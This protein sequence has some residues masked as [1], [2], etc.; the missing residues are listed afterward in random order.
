MN[1]LPEFD[2]FNT[3]IWN[4][5]KVTKKA[6]NLSPI[7]KPD[8]SPFLVHMTGKNQILQILSSSEN[9]DHGLI[10]AEIP[11]QSRSPWY[12][13]KIVCFTESVLHSIDSFRYIAFNRFKS[14]LFYG[15][16]F[17]KKKLAL[18]ENVRPALYID[19]RTIGSLKSLQDSLPESVE[20]YSRENLKL[21]RLLDRVIPFITPVFQDE[22][23][24]GYTW[25][26][27]WRYYKKDNTGFEF[28]YEDIEII[29]CPENEKG[30]IQDKLGDYSSRIQFVNTWGEYNEVIEFMKSREFNYG[31]GR[32]RTEADK[33]RS[34]KVEF[35]RTKN[36][37]DAYQAYAE[38]LAKRIDELKR[39]SEEYQKEISK[40]DQQLE[41]LE[42]DK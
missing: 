34:K 13:K 25:E 14:N 30:Q 1:R 28:S 4:E 21:K 41:Q 20:E 29:C 18:D 26:R 3:D 32:G 6:L 10:R 38:S 24:Q 31:Y 37:L 40:I 19:T 8:M 39:V 11:S 27:E 16:G 2:G 33:L 17:S 42:K 12:E 15:I 23:R 9:D 7:E 5:Y 22:V 36:Q 35:T